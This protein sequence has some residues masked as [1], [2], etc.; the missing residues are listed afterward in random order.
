MFKGTQ[1]VLHY[2]SVKPRW[3][4]SFKLLFFLMLGT[5]PAAGSGTTDHKRSSEWRRSTGGPAACRLVS[6]PEQWFTN[7]F[8]QASLSHPFSP[9]IGTD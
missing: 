9:L 1:H 6:Q 7:G 2:G 8:R 3:R 5:A 4:V